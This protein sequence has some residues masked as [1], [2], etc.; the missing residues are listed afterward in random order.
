MQV[1][2]ERCCGLDVHK[3]TVVACVIVPE[4]HGQPQKETRTFATLTENLTELGA[5]LQAKQVT[6]VAMESTGVYW[7]PVYNLLAGA[8]EILVV[9]A[10]HVKTLKG[11]KTDIQ[12]AEWIADL[13]RHGLLKGSF[14][15]SVEL[16]ALRDLTRYRTKLGDDRKS[17]I[18][19]L[20]KVLE[21]ANLKLSSV[22]TDLMGVSAQAILAELVQGNTNATL[23]AELAKGR[24]REKQ[25]QLEK[26]LVG[27][28]KPH[29]RFMLAQHLS[30]IEFLDE[31]ITRLDKQ[32]ADLMRPFEAE[33][34]AWDSLP[35]INQ[36]IAEIV[37]AEIG[38]DL[39]P[40]ADAQQLAS[41]AGMC[42]GNNESAGK[43]K[44][45]RTRKGSKWL[46]RALVE[47]AHGAARK[48]NS[49]YKSLYHRIAA[50][51]GKQRAA[52]AVG[53]SLLTTGF[54]LITRNKTYSDLGE[55][56]FDERDREQVKRR[57]VRRLEKLGFQVSLKPVTA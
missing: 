12:D 39:K 30:H 57:A 48:K 53:H 27:N 5:W 7:K 10:E 20:H 34:A 41:W 22:A 50:R 42:P 29:H 17:E 47:A 54:Y 21:D 40:F 35:G 26:A 45:G 33:L 23:L 14:I 43:R 38:A 46:R 13:L 6:H 32:I 37:I 56:Y 16:R 1:V 19:R 36:R 8:F 18:N 44:S 49:Y 55:N 11:R 24:L 9:N 2:Y 28:L 25:A 15:P 31:A 3:E 51:R 4:A 52:V